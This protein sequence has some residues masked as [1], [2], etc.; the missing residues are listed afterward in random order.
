MN[1]TWNNYNKL[2]V[3]NHPNSPHGGRLANCCMFCR[4]P[5]QWALKHYWIVITSPLFVES[6]PLL[7]YHFYHDHFALVQS[8]RNLR[9]WRQALSFSSFSNLIIVSPIFALS[10]QLNHVVNG[11]SSKYHKYNGDFPFLMLD[12]DKLRCL[13][14]LLSFII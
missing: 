11:A 3:H 6:P 7:A 4:A 5:S 10:F 14:Y 1:L 12:F 8:I 13:W 9:I 2:S